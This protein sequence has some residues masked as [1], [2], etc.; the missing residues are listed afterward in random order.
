MRIQLLPG[1]PLIGQILTE[2]N[3]GL[4]HSFVLGIERNREWLPTPRASRK[5]AE[6]DYLIVYGKLKDLEEHFG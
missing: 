2:V 3:S 5:L 6:D 1:S 4:E